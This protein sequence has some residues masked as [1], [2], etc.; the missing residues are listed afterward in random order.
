LA[1]VYDLLRTIAMNE[2]RKIYLDNRCAS[3]RTTRFEITYSVVDKREPIHPVL[4]D[5][6][7]R[8]LRPTRK[9][10]AS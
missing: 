7:W 10:A 8:A 9:F 3:P 1:C 4:A 5:E 6:R 2:V